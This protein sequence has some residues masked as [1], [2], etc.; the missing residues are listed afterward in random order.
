MVKLL[1]S[2]S[3][4]TRLLEN[5][6]VLRFLHMKI[7]IPLSLLVNNLNEPKALGRTIAANTFSKKTRMKRRKAEHGG[8]CCMK[9]I[10][11]TVRIWEESSLAHGPARF[12]VW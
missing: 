8:T 9:I 1:M 10:D 11:N 4:E 12:G 2:I 5:P 7:K 6:R 3:S